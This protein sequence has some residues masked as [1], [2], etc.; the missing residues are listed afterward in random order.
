MDTKLKLRIENWRGRTGVAFQYFTSPLKTGT[1]KE[2][3]D[4]LHLVFMMASAGIL[5]GDN[6]SY[7]IT[8]RKDTRTTITEQSYTKI[9]DTGKDGAK[10]HMEIEL[11]DHASLFYRPGAVI[12]FGGSCYSSSMN[13]RLS[14][15]SEFLYSD[16][17]SA[18]RIGMGEKFAFSH[19]RNY[20]CVMVDD[21]MVW[22]DHCC[23]EPE[24]MNLEEMV[25][26][27]GY[28]HQGT[29]YFYGTK[30]K[31]E[32]LLSYAK[33]VPVLMGKTKAAEGICIRVLANSAQDIEEIFD[34][35]ERDILQTGDRLRG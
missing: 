26:W 19:Y 15:R 11:E 25:F 9:F 28:T 4:R 27:D 24:K 35:A 12:P 10:K 14:S 23:L 8:C 31:Q 22:I 3:D 18:G 32:R 1:P 30:E 13:V 7:E 33:P 6:F 21:K 2:Q 20:V 34:E 16:I 17:L 5:K 29:L